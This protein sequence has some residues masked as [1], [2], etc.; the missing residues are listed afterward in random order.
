ALY[1]ASALVLKDPLFVFVL[2]G[3]IAGTGLLILADMHKFA[4]I[5]APSMMLVVMGLLGIHAERAFPESETVF[6]RKRFGL[7]FFFSGHALLG[8]GLMLLLG[9][10]AAAWI[11]H[12]LLPHWNIVSSDI[13][14]DLTLRYT[15]IALVLAG[16]YGYVYSELSVRRIGAYIYPAVFTLLWAELLG[17]QML[18]PQHG[19]ELILGAVSL[20]ALALNAV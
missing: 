19:I 10:Q 9:A 13:T 7:A 16:T 17:L 5:A 1:A 6:S 8:V 3:G 15:A 2:M 12:P 20:T 18:Q 11:V 4:E 14:T